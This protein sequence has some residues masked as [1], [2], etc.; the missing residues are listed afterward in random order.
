M[1]M[2][3]IEEVINLGTVLTYVLN[4]LIGI[5]GTMLL[6]SQLTSGRGISTATGRVSV[7]VGLD[8]TGFI[9]WVVIVLVYFFGAK[10]LWG[11]TVGGLLVDMV[12]GKK[13]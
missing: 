10:K 11:K 5:V 4:F 9:I 6:V 3:Y 7:G 8:M 13:K 1:F 12:M 2:L